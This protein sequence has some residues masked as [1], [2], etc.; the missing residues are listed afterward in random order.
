MNCTKITLILCV[1]KKHPRQSEL[2][3][4]RENFIKPLWLKYFTQMTFEI[5]FARVCEASRKSLR[6]RRWLE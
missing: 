4:T 2:N 3:Q 6:W 1:F 5:H